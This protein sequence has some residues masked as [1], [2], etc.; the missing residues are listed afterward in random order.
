M[1][2]FTGKKYFV[3]QKKEEEK[4][5]LSKRKLKKLTRLSVAELN[6]KTK[7]HYALEGIRE[8]LLTQLLNFVQLSMSKTVPHTE[9]V[10]LG[11][12]TVNLP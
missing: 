3:L 4:P 2:F 8:F 11:L 9:A 12:C 1:F 6:I 5:K 7:N 10:A